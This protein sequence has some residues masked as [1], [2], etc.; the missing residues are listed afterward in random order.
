[1]E[2]V[3]LNKDNPTTGRIYTMENTH[4]LINV[5]SGSV[6]VAFGRANGESKTKVFHDFHGLIDR[7]LHGISSVEI[8]SDKPAQLEYKLTLG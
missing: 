4:F 5:I 8:S 7:R 6:S 1:M 2:H 3:E